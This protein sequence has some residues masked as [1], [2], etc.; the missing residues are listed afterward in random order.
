MSDKSKN[1]TVKEIQE[2]DPQGEGAEPVLNG[3]NNPEPVLSESEKVLKI[4][5]ISD[6]M[7]QAVIDS[8]NKAKLQAKIDE[9]NG[10]EDDEEED[11]S[12]SLNTNGNGSKALLIVGIVSVLGIGT[13]LFLRRKNDPLPYQEDF[14]E[15]EFHYPEQ[16]NE[17]RKVF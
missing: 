10:V 15:D 9:M 14:D 4:D 11:E 17:N 5:D 12:I 1:P 13:Y 3:G 2:G 8:A 6:E 16:D 7:A